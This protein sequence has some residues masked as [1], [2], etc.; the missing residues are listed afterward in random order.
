[1]VIL[2]WQCSKVTENREHFTGL[3]VGLLRCDWMRKDKDCFGNDIIRAGVGSQLKFQRA[4][5]L[6]L[7][8]I[9]WPCDIL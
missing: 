5:H 8:A 2:F 6:L 7:A 1:M 9:H 4:R 3:V